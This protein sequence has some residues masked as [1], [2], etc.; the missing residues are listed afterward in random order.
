MLTTL[1]RFLQEPG[2]KV[3]GA[4]LRVWIALDLPDMRGIPGWQ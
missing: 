2:G 1:V 3:L 4:L